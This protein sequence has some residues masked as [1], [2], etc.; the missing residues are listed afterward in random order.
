MASRNQLVVQQ[1]AGALDRMKFEVAQELGIHKSSEVIPPALLY[2]LSAFA[3]A[4]GARIFLY[5]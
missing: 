4:D 1:A 3:E 2:S 5:P